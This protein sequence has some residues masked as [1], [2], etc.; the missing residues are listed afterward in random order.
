[1]TNTLRLGQVVFNAVHEIDPAFANQAR[2]T[3][4]DCYYVDSKI[5][6]FL[7]AWRDYTITMVTD[8]YLMAKM[9]GLPVA[10]NI[11]LQ[12][13]QNPSIPTKQTETFGNPDIPT[14]SLAH[15]EAMGKLKVKLYAYRSVLIIETVDPEKDYP[16]WTPAGGSRIGCVLAD[17]KASLGVSHE[18]MVWLK[19]VKRG[20]DSI[21]DVDWWKCNDGTYA[22][23]WLGGPLALKPLEGCTTSRQFDI[24][25]EHCIPI[26]NNPP[27]EAMQAVDTMLDGGVVGGTDD[28]ND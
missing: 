9:S 24:G 22:F 3:D 27:A 5:K 21:G 12:K 25:K 11:D 8:P 19:S 14:K 28:G 1:M 18:A 15:E 16:G 26:P 7:Q 6:V 17:T 2:G 20:R 23:G 4:Y 13:A 10:D